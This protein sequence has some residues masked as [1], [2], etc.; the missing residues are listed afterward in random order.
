[1]KKILI[2]LIATIMTFGLVGC[3]KSDKEVFK[4]YLKEAAKLNEM[5][6]EIYNEM[7]T[8]DKREWYKI[9][10]NRVR[11]Y[12]LEISKTLMPIKPQNRYEK[13]SEL[14]RLG[15]KCYSYA[16]ELWLLQ[17]GIVDDIDSVFSDYMDYYNYLVEL[18]NEYGIN[19]NDYGIIPIQWDTLK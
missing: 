19:L 13:T 7:A 10:S 8:T 5:E 6:R 3:A 2:L 15:S 17:K 11:D 1:M 16:Y 4:S 9:D 18:A 12:S 14:Q